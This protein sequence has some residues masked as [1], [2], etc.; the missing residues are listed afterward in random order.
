M[1][2]RSLIIGSVICSFVTDSACI[3]YKGEEIPFRVVLQHL[4]NSFKGYSFDKIV[5][6]EA[7]GPRVIFNND[8]TIISITDGLHIPIYVSSMPKAARHFRRLRADACLQSDA[9]IGLYTL[10]T[11]DEQDSYNLGATIADDG[12]ILPHH[13]PTID[14]T[15]PS[16]WNLIQGVRDLSTRNMRQE[17]I[18]CIHCRAGLGRS[19]TLA[20]AYLLYIYSIASKQYLDG[21][22]VSEDFDAPTIVA[23]IVEYIKTKRSVAHPNVQQRTAM[24]EFYTALRASGS[25]ENLYHGFC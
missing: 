20:A 14:F 21:T 4:I 8:G 5:E 15:A 7:T 23:M 24:R 16:I 22:P 10:N 19:V 2:R 1:L 12:F 11:S 6:A 25:L 3:Y 9:L 17:E 13:Y 18:T